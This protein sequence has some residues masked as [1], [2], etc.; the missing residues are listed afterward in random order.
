[1]ARINPFF[2]KR[3]SDG[4]V[5]VRM[6]FTR[7][8]ADIIEEAAGDTPLL[9]YLYEVI[10]ERAEQDAREARLDR[11]RAVPAPKEASA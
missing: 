4:S 2:F 1:M 5:R 6:R 10:N 9:P 3:D 7:E 8:E 11:A